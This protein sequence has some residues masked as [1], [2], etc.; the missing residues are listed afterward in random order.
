MADQDVETLRSELQQL[1]KDLNS[2][3][4]TLKTMASQ[5]G[6][7]AYERLR[8]GAGSARQQAE[9]AEQAVEQQIQ[10][11]PLTSLLVVF[12][13]GLLAGLFLHTRR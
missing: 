9:R 10:E 7:R 11:R 13:G 5:R 1:R 4:D 3:T 6:G 2:V 8:E 12:V